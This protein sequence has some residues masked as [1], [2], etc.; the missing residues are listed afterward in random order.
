MDPEKIKLLLA[1]C[2]SGA[3][4][5]ET[6]EKSSHGFSDFRKNDFQKTGDSASLFNSLEE[7]TLDPSSIWFRVSAHK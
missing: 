3:S 2:S 6:R 1:K 5:L 7:I 4:N